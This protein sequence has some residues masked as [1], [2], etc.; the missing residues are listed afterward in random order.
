MDVMEM[1]RIDRET[2]FDRFIYARVK[3]HKNF[4]SLP[5][6]IQE[7]LT[8]VQ[9]DV[10][11]ANY[12]TLGDI[13]RCPPAEWGANN[14]PLAAQ[15]AVQEFLQQQ[16]L[17]PPQ[18]QLVPPPQ[19]Q[20]V[21]PPQQ[22]LGVVA[23][24]DLELNNRRRQ[25]FV[26][27][28]NNQGPAAPQDPIVCSCAAPL[29]IP[30]L[31]GLC[32]TCNKIIRGNPMFPV[33]NAAKTCGNLVCAVKN[34]PSFVWCLC[35]RSL[36]RSLF[37]DFEVFALAVSAFKRF[38]VT[39]WSPKSRLT[40]DPPNGVGA[41]REFIHLWTCNTTGKNAAREKMKGSIEVTDGWE[42]KLIETFMKHRGNATLGGVPTTPEFHVKMITR[43]FKRLS[44]HYNYIMMNPRID[45]VC[46]EMRVSLDA[47]CTS[48]L[49]NFAQQARNCFEMKRGISVCTTTW[50]NEKRKYFEGLVNSLTNDECLKLEAR[51]N[52]VGNKIK[53]FKPGKEQVLTNLRKLGY[54]F[55]R[56]GFNRSPLTG[57]FLDSK[58]FQDIND[59]DF[60]KFLAQ[61]EGM[62][63]NYAVLPAEVVRLRNGNTAVPESDFQ[64]E[65]VFLHF[66]SVPW[67]QNNRVF[68][69]DGSA[70]LVCDVPANL[71]VHQ[72]KKEDEEEKDLEIEIEM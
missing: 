66:C 54:I 51:R 37:P 8:K 18:Q 3:F 72:K 49:P 45:I 29:E 41:V 27:V 63:F 15:R 68:N 21:P 43:M 60:F 6:A 20:L 11:N 67:N 62:K 52:I 14:L 36:S 57:R 4:E 28:I 39:G 22:Q 1:E 25:R 10:F 13:A 46:D 9:A 40:I 48:L 16:A 35:G 50:K 38:K 71:Y 23:D 24:P 55:V 19:Q 56:R 53:G 17:P 34:D 5:P 65:E 47:D 31:K 26:E 33:V 44:D 2:Y 42:R 64:R 59:R 12:F 69:D 70:N 7:Q 61:S 58:E 30:T 32:G